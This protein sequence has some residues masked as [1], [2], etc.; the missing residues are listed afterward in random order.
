M[1]SFSKKEENFTNFGENKELGKM[2]NNKKEFW[3]DWKRKTKMEEKAIKSLIKGKQ[4]IIKNI[5][6]EEIIAI[7]AKGSF[8]RRDMN[9]NSD[10]DFVTVLKTKKYLKKLKTLS[11][12]IKDKY[13]PKIQFGSGYTLW[14]LKTG[15]KINIKG[16]D[17]P[18]PSRINK[19][20]PHYKLLYGED[21]NKLRLHYKEDIRLLNGLIKTFH[22]LFLPNYGKKK[23]EFSEVVKQ[24]FWLVEFEQRSLGKN[25]PHSW[26]LLTKSIK[27]KNHII[28]NTLK[29]RLH[30]TKDKKLCSQYIKKL[31]RYLNN[32]EKK[33]NIS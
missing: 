6:K 31:K 10:V 17:K 16:S 30:P 28:H 26:K 22:N 7:Y 19:H 5:P 8:I 12:Q 3:K 33:L 32:L 24:V 29:Y 11:K 15:K 1:K 23:M 20:F 18:N 13:Y 27:D 2:I 21:V 4:I 25:V 14:E 9:K